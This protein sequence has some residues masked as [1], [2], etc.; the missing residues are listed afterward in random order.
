MS[1][2]C[3][4][5]KLAGPTKNTI[6]DFCVARKIWRNQTCFPFIN[7]CWVKK[8][9]KHVLDAFSVDIVHSIPK[10]SQIWVSV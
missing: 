10:S 7:V 3:R 2:D 9:Y 4:I 1:K 6:V 5:K 8:P